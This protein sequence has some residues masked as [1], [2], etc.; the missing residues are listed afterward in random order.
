MPVLK[1][2]FFPIRI[3]LIFTS[4]LISLRPLARKTSAFQAHKTS[5]KKMGSILPLQVKL[6]QTVNCFLK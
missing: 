4:Y 2:V 3:S 1:L 5:V 6:L